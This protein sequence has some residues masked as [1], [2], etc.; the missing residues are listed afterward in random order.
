MV[1]FT[2]QALKGVSRTHQ[3]DLL[4]KYQT[5]TKAD[6]VA[7]LRKHFLPLFDPTT[8]VAVVVT[9]PGNAEDV[10]NG[11]QG[12]GFEVTQKEMQIDPSEM[13]EYE[14]GSESDSESSTDSR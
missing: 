14:T 5:V 13:E 4:E 10:G 7:A 8:S 11:L 12:M 2:N 9:A 3:I 1:S 6:V